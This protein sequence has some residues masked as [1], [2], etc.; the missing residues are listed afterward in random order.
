MNNETVKKMGDMRLYGMQTAF[1]TFVEQPPSVNFTNNEMA[2]YLVQSEWDDRKHR[3][4]Q[5]N[6]INSKVPLRG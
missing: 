1:K 3:S 2:Q 6:I 5:R 4:L